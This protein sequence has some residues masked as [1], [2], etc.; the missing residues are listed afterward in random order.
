MKSPR[1]MNSRLISPRNLVLLFLGV[2][3]LMVISVT[4]ELRNSRR[5]LLAL[6]E[7]QSHS[8]LETVLSSSGNA[9]RTQEYLE[10]LLNHRLLDNAVLV[11]YL[12]EEQTVHNRLLTQITEQNA[13]HSIGIFNSAGEM[14]YQSNPED[15]IDVMEGPSP[16]QML[17]PIFTG[18]Q[19]TLLLGIKQAHYK[20]GYRYALALAG[21][22][23]SAI[24]VNLDAGQYLQLR[25]E[26]GFGVL[27]RQLADNAGVVYAALQDSGGIIAASGNVAELEALEESPFLA[28]AFARDSLSTRTTTF[29]SIRVFEAVHPFYYYGNQAGLLR[30]GLSLEPLQIINNRIY[31]RSIIMSLVLVGIGVLLFA[32]LLVKQ[33]MDLLQ[34]QYQVVETYSNKIIQNVSDAILVAN[35]QGNVVVCNNTARKLF[36]VQAGH[37]IG[38][39]LRS[40]LEKIGC[41]HIE[42]E[43]DPVQEVSCTIGNQRKHL[44]ISRS[45][46]QTAEETPHTILVIRDETDRRQFEEEMQRR[47]RLSAMG[48][49]ASGVAH[50]LRNPLNTIGTI[51]QQLDRDF[52]PLQDGEE[53]HEL[54]RIVYQEVRRMNQTIEEFLRLTRPEPVRPERFVLGELLHELRTQYSSMFTEKESELQLDLRWHGSVLWDRAKMRQVFMNLIQNASDALPS[55]GR[56]LIRVEQQDDRSLGI[57]FIDNGPGIPMEMR[58]QIFNLYYTTKSNG[59]GLG[60]SIVQRILSAHTG[61]IMVESIPERTE[62]RVIMPISYQEG[63]QYSD[64][65]IVHSAH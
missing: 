31:R 26:L 4:L 54:G 64:T 6:M 45:T 48:E 12:Y 55:G 13:L 29:D 16:Q 53:Y 41:P 32:A 3:L 22:D 30:L 10:Y 33:N 7:A 63:Y 11:K 36:A 5:D 44:V 24:V 46:V 25:Q 1:L 62:F 2:T 38:Q 61:R 39:E 34:R 23:Q 20:S 58:E 17:R 59:T 43:T 56:L 9:L 65:P 42:R 21:R 47:E 18:Q 27:L 19:D 51:I 52:E 37:V 8:L 57:F 14:I 40:F 35:G 50:E 60:L 28:N 15:S 49:L